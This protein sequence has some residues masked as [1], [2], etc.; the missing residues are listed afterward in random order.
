MGSRG[1]KAE[2]FAACHQSARYNA[3]V[4]QEVSFVFLIKLQRE[5]FFRGVT[6][7]LHCM[8]YCCSQKIPAHGVDV[9]GFIEWEILASND[10]QNINIL[11]HEIW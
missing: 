4:I 6:L 7:F 9:V 8:Q 11:T 2:C 5:A 10:S 1:F 3:Q